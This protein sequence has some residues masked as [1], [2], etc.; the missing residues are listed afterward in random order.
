MGQNPAEF[1]IAALR[2]PSVVAPVCGVG[3]TR[4]ETSV[5]G[6]SLG[7]SKPAEVAEFD[8]HCCGRERSNARQ[9]R[10]ELS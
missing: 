7:V 10:K 5:A 2:D 6:D 1:T 8:E 9:L 3:D 4:D